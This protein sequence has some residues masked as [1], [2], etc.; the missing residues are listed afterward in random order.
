MKLMRLIL[1]GM[2]VLATANR[3]YLTPRLAVSQDTTGERDGALALLRTSLV[4]EAILA[5]LVLA[6]VALLGNLE[7]IANA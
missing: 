7:P 1:A 3:F 4:A 5:A 2:L 6:A